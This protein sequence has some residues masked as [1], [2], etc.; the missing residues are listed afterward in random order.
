[1]KNFISLIFLTFSFLTYSQNVAPTVADAAVT[2]TEGATGQSINVTVSDDDGDSWTLS[3][4]SNPSVGTVTVNGNLSFT[5]DH[6][7]SEGNEVTFTYRATD[8]NNNE[9]SIATVTITVTG[10]NDMPTVEEITKT[11]DENSTTEIILSGNDPEGTA[12]VYSLVTQPNDGDFTFDAATGVGSYVHNGNENAS[13]TFSYKVCEDGTTNCSS[14][15]NIVITITN[16]ND[17]PIVADAV[18][19]LSEGSSVQTTLSISDPEGSALTLSV[20]SDGA[21]GTST[22]SGSQLTYTHD[23][24]ET[25]SDSV[26]FSVSDGTLSTTG[27]ITFTVS[28]VND[29]PTGVADTYYIS[30]TDT[31]K[32]S[33][34]VGVLRNDTDSDSKFETITSNLGSTSPAYGNLEYNSDGSFN[35]IANS[36]GFNSDTFSYI[37]SDGSSF[38]GEVTVTL[39][40]VDITVDPNAYDNVEASTLD[41]TAANG[42]LSNDKDVN[43]LTLTAAVAASPSYGTLTLAADGSFSYVHDGSENLR[44]VFTYNVTNANGD[45]SKTS[46]AVITHTNVNDSPTSA[47]TALTIN[48]GASSTFT[49]TYID[50]DTD[51]SSIVFTITGDVSNGSLVNNGD[52]TFSYSHAGT[53]TSSDSFV[54]SVSDGEFTI[55]DLAGTISVTAVNDVPVV[56]ALEYTLDEA[57]SQVLAFASTDAESDSVTYSVST[58]PTNGTIVSNDGVFTY[59]HNGSESS[60]DTF[61]YIAN[62]GTGNSQPVSVTITVTPVNDAPVVTAG[63]ISLNEGSNSSITLSA[64]DAEGDAMT[65]AIATAPTNGTV[66]LD[67]ATGA[68]TYTHSGGENTSDTFTFTSSDSALTS[69]AG[70]V[71][72][73]VTPVNDAPVISADTFAVDQFDEVTFNIPATDAEGNSLTYTIETDPTKGTLLDNGGGS[74]TY[75]N[76]TQSTDYSDNSDYTEINTDTFVVKANDGSLD[77]SDTTLTFNVTQ[78]N[79]AKPQVLLTSSASSITETS[80]GN[81]S[82]TVTAVLVDNDFYSVRR[83]MNATPVSAGA[84][85]SLGLIYLG[86]SNGKKYYVSKDE[87]CDNNSVNGREQYSTASTAAKNFGGYL[88]VFETE[89]EQTNV[90]NL[91]K[92]QSLAGNDFW[93]GY[94]YNYES[95]AGFIWANG[96]TGGGSTMYTDSGS[97]DVSDSPVSRRYVYFRSSSSSDNG[98]WFNT[99]SGNYRYILEFDNNVAASSDVDL[100]LSTGGTATIGSSED[101]SLSASTLTISAG[102]SSASITINEGATDNSDSDADEPTETIIITAAL[103]SEESDARIKSSQKTLSID[104]IDDDNTAVTWSSGGT[105]TEGSDSSVS[106][107]ATL[108]NVKPFDT[109]ITLDISGTATVEDDYASDDDG[110]ITTVKQI[111]EAY[112]LV[113]DSNGNIYV[114]SSNSRQIFK[115]DSSGNQTTYA[116]TGGWEDSNEASATPVTLAKFREIKSMAIDTSGS[117]DILYLADQRVIKKINLTTDLVYYITGDNQTWQNSFTNGEFDEAFFGNIEDIT[118]SNDGASLYILDQNAIRKITDLSGDGSVT[119]IS[120][121]WDWDYKDGTLSQARFEGPQGIDMDSS[122]NLWVRQYGKLRKV[123]LSAD[124]VTTVLSN[125]PWGSGDLTIDS[126]NTIYFADRNEA[127]LYEY[128]ITNGDLYT[129]IDSSNDRGTVDGITKNAKIERPTQ[130]LATASALYFTQRLGGSDGGLRKIDF[131][132]KLRIP[133]GQSSGTFTL[134]IIDDGVYETAETINVKVTAAENIQFDSTNVVEYTLADNDNAPKVS[135]VSSADTIAEEGGKATLTFQLGDA[136]ESGGKLDMSPGLKSSYIYLGEKDNHKYYLSDNHQSYTN[137]KQIATDAGGYL[138]AIDSASE[139]S[140]IRDQMES[141]GYNWESVWIGFNDEETEGTFKWVN[142][143]KSTYVN[144]QNGEPNNGGGREDYTELMNNGYWNDLPNDHN[145]RYVVEFSGSISS[146]DTVIEYAVTGSDGYETEFDNIVG[147]GSVT[148]SAG[149]S[150]KTVEIAA[151]SDTAN[152]P[153]DSITYTIT[154]VTGDSEGAQL[155]TD[156]SKTVQINDNDAP[157]LSWAASGA[158]LEEDSGTVSVTATIDGS[159]TKLS[160]S[161]L[162]VNVNPSSDDTAVY[163]IDYEIVE[164]NQV[165]TFAGSGQTGSNDG[166]GTDAKFRYPMGSVLDASG[167]LYVADN[168]NNLI[169][170]IDTSGNV[171]TWAGNG[172]WAHDRN[173]GSKLDVGFARPAILV[174]DASGNMYVAENGR[175]RISKVDTAGNVTH[176]SG[177]GDWGDASGD[178]NSTQFRNI[179]GMAFDSSGNLFVSERDNHKVKRI[180]FD[181]SSGAA[182]SEDWVGS[183]S[184]DYA[185]GNGTD[186]SFRHPWGIAIDASDNLYVSDHNNHRIRKVTP[187]KDVTDY[188]GNGNWGQKDG[189]LA[190]AR[191]RHPGPLT[192]DSN[193]DLWVADQGSNTIIKID[194]SE[195]YVSRF[196]GKVIDNNSHADGTLDEAKFSRPSSISLNST[197][198]FVVDNESH[199]VRKIDLL[200]SITIPATQTSASITLRGIDDYNFEN[201]ESITLGVGTTSN[202]DATSSFANLSITLNSGD[203]LPVVRL[204]S[205]EDVLDETGTVELKVSL[206]DAFSS[207]KLDMIQG[208]KSDF[209]YLGEYKGSK[210]Y[211]AKNDHLQ[212]DDANAR[213]AELGGQ[214]AVITSSGEQDF[215]VNGIYNNDP[216]FSADNNRWLSHWIGLEF[217]KDDDTPVWEWSNGIVSNYSAWV[218]DWQENYNER[219]EAAY[220]HTDGTWHSN[221]KRSHRRYVIEFS[222][223]ISDANTTIGL[224]FDG[225]TATADTDFTSDLSSGNVVIPAGSANATVTLTGVSADGDEPIEVV[226][227]NL[228]SAEGGTLSDTDNST[229]FNINDSDLPVVTLSIENDVTEISENGGT[230]NILASLSNEKL[231]SVSI[232]FAFASSGE[233]IAIFDKDYESTDINK[234]SEFLGDGNTGFLDGDDLTSSRLSGW[235]GNLSKDSAGNI[236]FADTDNR[237]IRKIDASGN[238][239][240]WAGNGNCCD[241]QTDIFRTDTDLRRPRSIAFDSSGNA[242]IAESSANRIAK[243][244]SS[245]NLTRWSG[246]WDYGRNNGEVSQATYQDPMDLLFDSQG[247]LFVLENH[248]IRKIEFSGDQAS[249]SDFVGNGQWGDNDGTGTDAQFGDVQSFTIDS[250]D[251]IYFADRAHQRIKKVTPEGVVTTIAG[252]GNWDFADGYGTGARFR[253]PSGISID[254]DDNLYVADQENNRIRKIELTADGRYKVSTLAGDGDYGSVNGV[255][256]QAQFKRPEL[257]LANNGVLYVYVRDESKIKKIDLNPQIIIPAGQKTAS[258]NISGIDD[259][260]YESTEKISI[261][262]SASGGTLASADPL[263]LNLTSDDAIPSIKISADNLILDENGGTLQVDVVLTDASGATGFWA[264]SDLPQNAQGDYDFV[265]EYKGHKYYFSKFNA[266]WTVANQNALDLGGQMLV[267]DD[268]EEQEFVQSIM[269]HN[270]TWVGTKATNGPWT[271]NYGDSTFTNFDYAPGNN[272]N[273]YVRTYGNQWYGHQNND[274]T[275]YIVEFG[276]VKTSELPS[277]IN[278]VFSG[279]A[280]LDS[281]YSSSETAIT[282]PAGSQSVSFTLTGINDETDEP[283]EQISVTIADPENVEISNENSLEF[284]ISDDEKPAVTFTVSDSEIAEN[285]GS[286]TVTAEISN[287]KISPVL[288]NFDLQGTSII[289]QDYN[290]TSINRF[291]RLAGSVNNQGVA[292]G[293]GDQ[294]RFVTPSSI[295]PYGTSILVADYSVDV[296]KE[297]KQDG[298]VSTFLG[299]AYQRGNFDGTVSKEETRLDQ[300]EGMAVTP[301]GIVYIANFGGNNILKYD[302][303]TE[304][305]TVVVRNNG[306][307][308]SDGVSGQAQFRGPVGIELTSNG[309]LFV[310]EFYGHRIRL[311]S[312]DSDGNPN[313]QT[314]AGGGGGEQSGDQDGSF[315][316]SRF[317]YPNS[318]LLDESKNVMYVTGNDTP[319][320]RVLDFNNNTVSTIFLDNIYNTRR[321]FGIASDNSGNL[322]TAV[323]ER[324][325]IAKVSFN[326]EGQPYYAG[327]ISP[328]DN[329]GDD[330]LSYPL[331]LNIANG[332]MY[333][334]NYN[335]KTVDKIAL[336]AGIEIPSEIKTQSATFTAFKDISFEEDETI[337]IKISSISNGE[338]STNDVGVVTIIESTRLSKVESPFIGV[339]NGKVSWGDYDRDGDM[340]LLL[341]GEAAEG[342]ITNIYRNNG[343]DSDGNPVFENTNQNFTKYKGGDIEF[344]DVDQDGWLDVAVTG[345]S[346]DGRKSELYMNQEGVFFELNTNYVV[347]GLSQSDMQW[348]DLDNDSDQDLIITGIDKENRNQALYYTNLGNFNFFKEELFRNQSEGVQR[349]EI[350]I[351]D[352]DKDGDNDLFITGVSGDSNQN[353]SRR[354]YSN[355]YYYNNPNNNVNVGLVDGNT[356]YLDIDG[357]GELDYLSI[358]RQDGNSEEVFIESNLFNLNL[359]KLKD[360]DFDFADYNNDGM[361]DLIITGEDQNTGNAVSKLYL[362]FKELYG[363][364]YRLMESDLPIDALRESNASW[365]DYDNDGDLDLFLTGLDTDGVPKSLLYKA[366][367][368]FNTNNAP[369]APTNVEAFPY[370]GG[371]IWI[372]WDAPEDD[373]SSSFRYSVRIGTEPGASDVLYANSIIDKDSENFGSTLIDIPG[374]SSRTNYNARV[375]PGT[376]YISVQAIDGGNVGGAFSEEISISRDFNWNAQR[377]GGIID[378]RLL[379]SENSQLKFMD[380]D[381][382][383]DMDLIGSNVGTRYTGRQAINILAFQNDIYEPKRGFMNGNSTFE[384]ADFNNDGNSDIIVSVDEGTGSR[385]TVLLNTY[386]QDEQRDDGGREYFTER[387]FFADGNFFSGLFN[388]KFAIKDLNNDGLLEVIAAGETSKISSEATARIGIF[389]IDPFNEDN[390]IGFDNFNFSDFTELGGEE[391]NDLSFSS[392]DFG[393]ID[394]DGDFDFIIS[395]YSFDGYKT[396]LYENQRKLD[397]NGAV[398]QPVQVNYVLTSNNF[399]SVK[400]GTTQ[401]VDID[402]DGLLDIIFSGQSAEGDIFRAYKNTGNIDN[403]ASIDI[404]LPAVRNGNFSF[405]DIFGQGYND[406]VYSG[407]V[408][409]QGTFSRIAYIDPEE[410]K[411]IE[412]NYNLNV[413]DGKIGLADFDGDDDLDLIITGKWKEDLSNNSYRGFV[414]IN[415]RGYDQG[416]GGAAGLANSNDNQ[417]KTSSVSGVKQQSQ[418]DESA[419]QGSSLNTKPEPPTTISYQRQRIADKTYEVVLNWNSGTDK[420]TPDEALTYS[421]M[422]G[423]SEGAQDIL[424]SGANSDGKRSTGTKGNAENNKSWKMILSEG[425]YHVAVQSVDASFVGS[426][427]SDSFKFTVTNSNKLGDSNGDDTVNIL[428]LTSNVDYILGNTPAVFVNEVA[429]VNGDG[430]INVADISGIVN[431]IMNGSAGIAQGSTYDPYKWEYFSDKPVGDATLVRRD[432][433]IFLEN[434]KP[435]TSLQFSVD[436]SVEYELS[437]ELDNV[438]VVNFVEDN[439]RT[440]LIYSF[441]NQPID[442]LTDVIFEYLDLNDGDDFEIS[443]LTAGTRDGLLLKLKYSDESFFDDSEDI[444]QIYP[445][446]AVSNVNLL[447]D[448]TKKVETI[449]VDFYNILGVSVYKTSID[450]M[451]RLNDLDVSM[452]TSGVYTVRVR[453]VTEKNE[454]IINVHKLIKK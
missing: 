421:L 291:S 102:Q 335:S 353:I 432:G 247:N 23:G 34:K 80:A 168:D 306:W 282:V 79:L 325:S 195:G 78:I 298:T 58:D 69:S 199:R 106:L 388:I 270:G 307:G 4:V 144:W 192:F 252:N 141:A 92:A 315:Q 82:L 8:S 249:I 12:L 271:N 352:R 232:P 172:D 265:G 65:Y 6:D 94:Q 350:D 329:N 354:D 216:N 405:G 267:I 382:D 121:Q 62:D 305:T 15:Q 311:I 24:S 412:S 448:I 42:L 100:V 50:T 396:Y 143:S 257:T 355:T 14:S 407:T 233:K 74:F 10:V 334:S 220:L 349:G 344:V 184:Y 411:Y 375:L 157:V 263:E 397:E 377:L 434:D 436:S 435:V 22:V 202:V 57:G 358:G 16:V 255:G 130:L 117:D 320:I 288:V 299:K 170:K 289:G 73:T 381:K 404:G 370:F 428:D 71:T 256:S 7:G 171:T 376:Y 367:N 138:T 268:M 122:G 246:S 146:V 197:S 348:A 166:I 438:T 198:I 27:T 177:N 108:N 433:R 240:T 81:A 120:G 218:D 259:I 313:V 75:F 296:I 425:E 450:S 103:D 56:S 135:L 136:S 86:E 185:N 439:K 340:D 189:S 17:A 332:V 391:L 318:M 416:S 162:N 161:T 46:F 338:S 419:S 297:I 2:I 28:P 337:E 390:S 261:T 327:N 430:D 260:S 380:M 188:A 317:R 398:V 26:T 403:F 392:F 283:V 429:D 215:I 193:G 331:E 77:S 182:T 444:M 126:S 183:G 169:R 70:T 41:V 244:D 40:V 414:Y 324:N 119:T 441:N 410:N 319:G 204:S 158:T 36:T 113:Q 210:Y 387:N 378:R 91:L 208:S 68:L 359:P 310:S 49:P 290:S 357:D 449:E 38:G 123:D 63:T 402:Q 101:Y 284:K 55:S 47:G 48:E 242:F 336:G 30:L 423:T 400:D 258:F 229:S 154:G 280:T 44:D 415:V 221:E 346:P 32:I 129:L 364:E 83:D 67:A 164:L 139:N 452:L 105:I 374:L 269:I 250:N 125:M 200:P 181:P 59:T 281:D 180:T 431:I 385:I 152:D 85:N 285:G 363:E 342:T 426:K 276:P 393:D 11:V 93:I 21:N 422:I 384:L 399:V 287:P 406:L 395:G 236:Y 453:M 151:S 253:Q 33:S 148:I 167:N 89:T 231:N 127:R 274:N 115:I 302:P 76:N 443:D 228:A 356:E 345:V 186:A 314:V 174:F 237:V 371:N 442:E 224:N 293:I 114:S 341:M 241:D 18:N 134:S 409:G 447:T 137:A 272:E 389:S 25:T 437:E 394:N 133:A 451:G 159:I 286:T 418:N 95:P 163:G 147:S 243:I 328:L 176:V 275:H 179:A 175:Q 19:T 266:S 196:A 278:L 173:E 97:F 316:D 194:V 234:V 238:L 372:Q 149:Q 262:P 326:D 300:A 217:D 43:N 212:F 225:S 351:I 339:Q 206:S 165:S 420:E 45:I 9:S 203:P 90:N 111:N 150:V 205:Q 239:T 360:V 303:N 312:F 1:M 251:N 99:A 107:T 98:T 379:T 53:E 386:D 365:I 292:D 190:T 54:Y 191:F 132:N 427:F 39:E 254:S 445:N 222:S 347:E 156:L 109:A 413:D 214:L 362:T 124:A 87:C 366:E 333:I 88:A 20:S 116:G 37:P 454:E 264:N 219:R 308:D 424:A 440:F 13:D 52:G 294:A 273:G 295:V 230:V 187:S 309:D 373:N 155:G 223:A 160:S 323:G 84:E 361:S 213:A 72:V 343:N 408:T 226:T 142:G 61:Q 330:L 131:I 5:Y 211:S 279:D 227:V 178:K 118:V 128:S 201:A 66:T 35:Y 31:L 60:S 245:G 417:F 321:F 64:S 140:F 96:W 209:Y 304:Q 369:S 446:P 104:L 235:V 401:F 277:A 112:G 3:V 248:S 145:R 110:F 322:Y 383:G 207:P 368:R 153:I 29:A 301:E 51:L